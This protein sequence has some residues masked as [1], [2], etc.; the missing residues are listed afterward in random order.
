MH[1]RIPQAYFRRRRESF[2]LQLCR[3]IFYDPFCTREDKCVHREMSAQF[4]LDKFYLNPQLLFIKRL[5]KSTVAAQ[6][7]LMGNSG[8]VEV[9]GSDH[10]QLNFLADV[11]YELTEE[12]FLNL[13]AAV[14]FLKRDVNLDGLK[15]AYTFSFSTSYIF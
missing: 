11:S 10:S 6:P 5:S 15:R 14:P 1:H 3:Y 4:Q 2:H 8:Y 13:Q 7:V 9:D 12:L